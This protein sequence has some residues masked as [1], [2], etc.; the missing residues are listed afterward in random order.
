VPYRGR[1]KGTARFTVVSPDRLNKR[2]L[3]WSLLKIEDHVLPLKLLVEN[4]IV[5]ASFQFIKAYAGFRISF[6]SLPIK[7]IL[8]IVEVVLNKN[9]MD[10]AHR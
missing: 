4:P 8:Q 1:D 10:H 6:L 2:G 9:D 3:G 5:E 7:S